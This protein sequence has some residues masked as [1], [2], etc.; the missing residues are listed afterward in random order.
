MTT[1]NSLIDPIGPYSH[2]RVGAALLLKDDATVT[3]L[4]ETIL[5]TPRIINGANVENSSYPAGACAE[6]VAMDTAV[7]SFGIQR[8][9]I[10]AVGVATDAPDPS[11]PCGFCRQVL[12]EF[13]EVSR[14]IRFVSAL[15]HWMG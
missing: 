13:C 6:R 11:S 4:S 1:S 14:S 12:R 15:L 8:G 9:G 5:G 10:R 7:V 3:G 2:F